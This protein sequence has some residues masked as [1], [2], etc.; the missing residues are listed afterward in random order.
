[1]KQAY[2]WRPQ[3]DV[4]HCRKLVALFGLAQQLLSRQ[5]HYDWG[6]RALKTCLAIS[7]RLLREHRAAGQQLN[8]VSETQIIIRGVQL[9]TMPKL[10]FGDTNRCGL[11]KQQWQSKLNLSPL[12]YNLHFPVQACKLI[13]MSCC[14]FCF[15]GL[16]SLCCL[17]YKQWPCVNAAGS[18]LYWTIYFRV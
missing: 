12:C 8:Q 10:T 15:L 9:A 5:Q 17:V 14:R 18:K 4:L 11:Q 3:T 7:G 6:L 2:F 13:P 16:S 1:M